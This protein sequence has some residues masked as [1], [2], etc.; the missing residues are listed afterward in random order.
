M[1]PAVVTVICTAPVLIA[2]GLVTFSWVA[3]VA[4][5][6]LP[7]SVP[8]LTAVAP[9]RSVPV[10]VTTVPPAKGPAVGLMDAIVGTGTPVT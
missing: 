7:V 2:C 5:R 9:A 8:N 4:L 10:T 1:P 6:F 3:D